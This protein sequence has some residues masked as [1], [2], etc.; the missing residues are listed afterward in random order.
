ML[1]HSKCKLSL[2]FPC[3]YHMM[4]MADGKDVIGCPQIQTFHGEAKILRNLHF[5]LAQRVS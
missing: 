4:S 3:P 2:Y 1:L 5:C